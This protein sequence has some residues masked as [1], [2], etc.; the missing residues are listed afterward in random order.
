WFG[1]ATAWASRSNMSRSGFHSRRLLA[2]FLIAT[3]AGA[4]DR[5]A[6]CASGPDCVAVS[7]KLQERTGAG[8]RDEALNLQP[9]PPGITATDEL[10]ED[11]AVA[12]ALWR[13]PRLHV[14][15]AALGVARAD[16]VDAG[17]LRNFSFQVLFPVG[18]KPFESLLQAPIDALWERPRRVAAARVNL[19]QVGESVVQNGLDLV[20][21]VRVACADLASADAAAQI[22]A[23]AADLRSRIAMLTDKRLAAG[24]ISEMEAMLP[25][26]D[27]RSVGDQALRSA[28]EREVVRDRLRSL[29]GLRWDSSPLRLA[30]IADPPEPPPEWTALLKSAEEARP[31]L[32]AAELAIEVATLRAKWERSRVVS[33][34][35]PLL[36]VKD[37]GSAGVR[38]GPGLQADVPIFNRNQGG[39]RR[40]DAEV[41]R[42]AMEYLTLRDQV[43]LD[44]RQTRAHYVQAFESLQ[45]VRNEIIPAVRDSVRLAERAFANGDASYLFALEAS[46][47]LF[48]AEL[49]ET[50]EVAAARRAAADLQRAA[51]RKW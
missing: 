48:D 41:H 35:A 20:R 10:T 6:A 12:I 13:N 11:Q 23:R 27:A 30:R 47:Q 28:R 40:A 15:L 43:E 32:R 31:D 50:Q 5:V 9:L 14:A 19:S 7:R 39:I 38:A 2:G 4:E 8:L 44:V 21:D 37:V 25:R 16:L 1:Y 33:I 46:R 24:D 36:S 3:A 29:L 42:R 22:I 26:I 49:R 17:L 45:R 34:L 51:G 18:P